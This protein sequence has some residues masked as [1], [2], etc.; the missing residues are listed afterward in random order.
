[1]KSDGKKPYA[2][3]EFMILYNATCVFAAGMVCFYGSIFIFH[4]VQNGGIHF[5]GNKD[6]IDTSYGQ[7]YMQMAFQW[8][9]YQK[10]WEFMDTFI[11]ML[12]QKW[13]QA[14]FLH[15]YHHASITVVVALYVTF[16]ASGDSYIP[17]LLNSGVHVIM[18]SY[19]LCS[20]VKL[21][22]LDA[23]KPYIT[24]MQITQFLIIAAQA[25]LMWFMG[26]EYGYPDFLKIVMLIYMATMIYLFGSFAMRKYGGK[27]RSTGGDKKKQ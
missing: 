27:K 21:R 16:D 12:R 15:I 11:F 3:K 17:I 9:Y 22:W 24:Y 5:V 13:E 7:A 14:S 2:L 18:Y 10:F 19:Y 8:F 20:A 6:L 4:A 25:C 26:P 1:M 23:V